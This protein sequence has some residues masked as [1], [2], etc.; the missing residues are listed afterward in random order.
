MLQVRQPGR[1]LALPFAEVGT[2]LV[3]AQFVWHLPGGRTPDDHHIFP[4]PAPVSSA[5]ASTVLL[6]TMSYS[7]TAKRKPAV[8]S[9]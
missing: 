2:L 4:I 8:C 3:K 9:C 5:H 6:P 7:S 1:L